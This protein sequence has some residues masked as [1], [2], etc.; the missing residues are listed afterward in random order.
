M[1]ILIVGDL[2]CDTLAARAAIDHAA[3]VHADVI[4]QLGDFGFWPRTEP[5]RKFLRKV[6]ARL[7]QVGVDLW[8]VDGNHDDH[9]ALAA[10]PVRADGR[11]RVSDHIWH[12]P[13]GH[14]WTWEGTVWVAAG[15]AVSV[16]Q[17]WRTEGVSWFPEEALTDGDVNAI[18]AG[19]KA[20]VLISHDAPW[21]VPTLGRELQLDRP[22]VQRESEWPA[23]LLQASDDHMHRVRNIVDRVSASRVFHG[24]HH[25]RYD[26]LLM[27]AHG[28]VGIAGLGDNC[29]PVDRACIVVDEGGRLA[30]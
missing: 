3:A 2:H 14:R 23:D 29:G 28:A 22:P 12:L 1:R 15:G 13:R 6:E 5:G 8:W 26:D 9:K 19:G 30:I 20:Q 10:R 25:V 7:G 18:V 24:H 16:D 11:R 4:L 27:S 17:K 21:G